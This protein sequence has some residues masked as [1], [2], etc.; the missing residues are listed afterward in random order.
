MIEFQC[1]TTSGET[2]AVQA[3]NSF[4]NE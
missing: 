4:A 1:V 3:G 2:S